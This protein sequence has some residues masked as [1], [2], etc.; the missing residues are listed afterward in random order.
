MSFP[1][2]T[3]HISVV[4]SLLE[5]VY[6]SILGHTRF[7]KRVVG[8]NIFLNIILVIYNIYLQLYAQE[9]SAKVVQ[10]VVNF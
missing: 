6:S 9:M 8:S 2:P 1:H 4:A 10:I 3:L 7:L 5:L